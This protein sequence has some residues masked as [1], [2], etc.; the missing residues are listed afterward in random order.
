MRAR[1]DATDWRILKELQANGRITN[2]ELAR[3]VGISAPGVI[4]PETRWSRMSFLA[5]DSGM[6]PPWSAERAAPDSSATARRAAE[7]PPPVPER[8][9]VVEPRRDYNSR[10]MAR[11]TLIVN[12]KPHLVNVDPDTPLL[13]VLRDTLEMNNPRFGCGLGQCGACT[14]LVD[15]RAVRSCSWTWGPPPMPARSSCCNG[16]RWPHSTPSER[17]TWPGPRSAC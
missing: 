10:A 14:V 5:T 7:P 13:Y 11:T 9:R 1:L 15:N 8:A 16:R 4:S 17:W 2:V 3:R 12:G 6:A